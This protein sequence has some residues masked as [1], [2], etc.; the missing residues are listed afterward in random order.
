MTPQQADVNGQ[1][2]DPWVFGGYYVYAPSLHIP[3]ALYFHSA[4]TPKIALVD[5]ERF[6]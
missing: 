2:L 5:L 4:Y 3:W 6:P 1:W